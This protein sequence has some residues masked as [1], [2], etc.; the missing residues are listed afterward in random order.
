MSPGSK[1]V[2]T[3][4]G[5]RLLVYLFREFRAKEKLGSLPSVQVDELSAQFPNISEAILRKR[6][7][8]CAD[9][10]VI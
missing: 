3:Y 5:N 4:L 8:H 10:Q 7:K 1:N 2:Q 6:V 9:L